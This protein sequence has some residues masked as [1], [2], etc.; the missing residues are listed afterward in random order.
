[1]KIMKRKNKMKKMEWKIKNKKENEDNKKTGRWNVKSKSDEAYQ[2]WS[3]RRVNNKNKL[4]Y[5][6]C[7]KG[8]SKWK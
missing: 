7:S 4:N 1:M 5:K 2:V 3:K 6:K 8:R